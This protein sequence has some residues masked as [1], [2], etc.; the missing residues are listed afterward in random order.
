MNAPGRAGTFLEKDISVPLYRL[1]PLRLPVRWLPAT[2]VDV[3]GESLRLRNALEDGDEVAVS[4]DPSAVDHHAWFRWVTAHQTTFIIWQLLSG[5]VDRCTGDGEDISDELRATRSYVRGYSATLLY[6]SSCSRSVYHRVVRPA[7]SR[8]HPAISGA[9]ASDYWPVRK[10]LSGRLPVPS[11]PAGAALTREIALNRD[12]HEGI[13]EKLVPSGGSLLQAAMSHEGAPRESRDVL[14]TL[15]DL[16]FATVRTT[17]SYQDVVSQFYR[18]V[19]LIDNDIRRVGLDLDP[20]DE[21][22]PLGRSEI[23]ALKQNLVAELR[24]AALIAGGGRPDTG[25]HRD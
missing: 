12:I 10:L 21:H 1:E 2:E 23:V 13:A 19:E 9:W 3:I 6:A 24:Q 17:A 16:V 7:M 11:T 4:S 8:Q 25:G 18:R 22:G 15:Y 5:A 14:T 20:D